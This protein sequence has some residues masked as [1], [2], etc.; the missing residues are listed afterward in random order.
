[1]DEAANSYPRINCSDGRCLDVLEER[2]PLSAGDLATATGLSPGAITTLVDRLESEGFVR[3]VTDP[4]DRRRVLIELT[5]AARDAILQTYGPM[6]ADGGPWLE[7]RND[8]ELRLLRDF[9]Q[10]GAEIN[11][12]NADRVGAMPRR[13]GARR[14]GHPRRPESA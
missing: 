7:P 13:A 14:R 8:D 9:L 4:A 10:L 2:V 5:D 12:K 3:R 11:L 1:M 6:A